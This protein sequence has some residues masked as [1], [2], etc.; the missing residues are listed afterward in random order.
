MAAAAAPKLTVFLDIDGVLMRFGNENQIF[1]KFQHICE[2]SQDPNVR[3]LI[4]AILKQCQNS[5]EQPIYRVLPKKLSMEWREAS[6]PFL[7]PFAVQK[8][9]E[10]IETI[11]KLNRVVEIVISSTWRKGLTVEQLKQVFRVYPFSRLIVDKTED[12]ANKILATRGAEIADYIDKHPNLGDFLIVD[13]IAD[14]I[15]DRPRLARRFVWISDDRLFSKSHQSTGLAIVQN[16]KAP[17]Q[18]ILP[19]KPL[20][21]TFK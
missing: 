16:T 1:L 5:P 2:N 3:G 9:E 18:M 6:A 21:F 4:Q 8:F 12:N 15:S 10:M 17:D 13:D 14:G 7:N 20:E 11:Q 19:Q